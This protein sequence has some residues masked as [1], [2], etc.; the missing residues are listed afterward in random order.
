MGP[1]VVFALSFTETLSVIVPVA[2]GVPVMF[3]VLPPLLAA[4]MVP[5]P[6]LTEPVVALEPLTVQV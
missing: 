4:C 3:S 2:E 1:T 5:L 6:R